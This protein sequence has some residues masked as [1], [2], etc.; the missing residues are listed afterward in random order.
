M[1][2]TFIS[3]LL[4]LTAGATAYAVEVIPPAQTEDQA[5]AE[6]LMKEN[7]AKKPSLEQRR[8]ELKKKHALKKQQKAAVQEANAKAK[9]EAAAKTTV[10]SAD[11]TAAQSTKEVKKEELQEMNREDKSGTGSH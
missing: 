3:L 10:V 11:N 4:C 8:A 7:E 9:A 1:K 2:N 6:Q 5:K